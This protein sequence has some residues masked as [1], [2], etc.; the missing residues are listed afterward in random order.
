M[1][2]RRAR[3]AGLLESAP[4]PW[5][6]LAVLCS[7]VVLTPRC[8]HLTL[9]HPLSPTFV[10]ETLSRRTASLAVG[11][12]SPSLTRAASADN[13]RAR[14]TRSDG[15]LWITAVIDFIEHGAPV[16]ASWISSGDHRVSR[17]RFGRRRASERLAIRQWRSCALA[18]GGPLG[19]RAALKAR[20]ARAKDLPRAE[21][22]KADA[23]RLGVEL[24]VGALTSFDGVGPAL[25]P[26]ARLDWALDVPVVFQATLAGLGTRPAVATTAGSA[27]VSQQYGLLGPATASARSVSATVRRACRRSAAHSVRGAQNH[28]A[29]SALEKLFLLEA[30]GAAV[31]LGGRYY[32]TFATHVQLAEPYLA[33]HFL[34]AEVASS[35][36]PNLLVPLTFGAWL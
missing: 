31:E 28:L 34:D 36:R 30:R 16:A 3:C 11:F 24:G 6:P 23:A 5:L 8:S 21:A 35:G 15:G 26:M 9:L 7:T 32:I 2:G 17:S 27:H 19:D 33:I 22:E 29:G 25:L 12:R 13:R 20:V 1:P 4:V 18:V 14:H 10:T